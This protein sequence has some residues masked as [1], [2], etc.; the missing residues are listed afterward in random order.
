MKYGYVMDVYMP[1]SKDN[2]KE[3]RGFGFVTFE[4]EA[5]IQVSTMTEYS[6][7]NDDPACQ[8]YMVSTVQTPHPP[9]CPETLQTFR[10]QSL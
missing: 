2:K 8:F 3:H 7:V 10:H 1:R 4:T 6:E 5:A 9:L